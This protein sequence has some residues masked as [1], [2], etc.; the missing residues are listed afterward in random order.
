MNDDNLVLFSCVPAVSVMLVGRSVGHL[1][2]D[3]ERNGK[4]RK[5]TNKLTNIIHFH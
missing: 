1:Q 3:N 2:R 4:E 5:E